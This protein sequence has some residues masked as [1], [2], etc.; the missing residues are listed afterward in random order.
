MQLSTVLYAIYPAFQMKQRQIFG[1]NQLSAAK[2]SCAQYF[3][4]ETSVARILIKSNARKSHTKIIFI[5]KVGVNKRFFS[6]LCK[7]AIFYYR[8]IHDT[9]IK[10]N[11]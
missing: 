10:Y 4:V 6:K 9:K 2:G 5:Q 7:L 1:S 3:L 11:K 8:D